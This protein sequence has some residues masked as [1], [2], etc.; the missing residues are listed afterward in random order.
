M[1]IPVSHPEKHFA[2]QDVKDLV[3]TVVDME[4]R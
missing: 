3:L 1:H 4:G 2:F